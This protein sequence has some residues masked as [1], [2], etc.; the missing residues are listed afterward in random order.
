MRDVYIRVRKRTLGHHLCSKPCPQV[1]GTALTPHMR[2]LNCAVSHGRIFT[3][4]RNTKHYVSHVELLVLFLQLNN[5]TMEIQIFKA[6]L[7]EALAA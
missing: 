2:F 6:S 1:T 7:E 4:Q 3:T 5:D